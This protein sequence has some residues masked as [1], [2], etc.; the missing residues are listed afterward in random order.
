MEN[1]ELIKKAIN[2]AGGITQLSVIIK[3]HKQTIYHWLSGRNK[4]SLDNYKK[5]LYFLGD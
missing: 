4:L 2:K 3:I 1:L 5:L